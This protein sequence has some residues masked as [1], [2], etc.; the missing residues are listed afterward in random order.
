MLPETFPRHHL[1]VPV[2]TPGLSCVSYQLSH[3]DH[4]QVLPQGCD[5]LAVCVVGQGGGKL[6][7]WA[8]ECSLGAGA[9]RM[10]SAGTSEGDHCP[11]W[12]ASRSRQTSIRYR[13]GSAVDQPGPSDATPACP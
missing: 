6:C 9:A 13:R 12:R 10:S 4:R 8:G 11:G 7:V 5:H 1:A 3:L 2:V